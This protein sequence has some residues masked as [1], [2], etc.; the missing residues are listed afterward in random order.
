MGAADRALDLPGI[1]STT[2]FV[3]VGSGDEARGLRRADDE[4]GRAVRLE[5]REH[6]VEPL[7]HPGRKRV[8]TG[9]GAVE[10]QPCFD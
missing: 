10:Q 7:D 2:E 9:I 6:A 4:A 3:D 5:L 1:G 8:G